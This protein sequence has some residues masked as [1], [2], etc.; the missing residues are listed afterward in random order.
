MT[1]DAFL[2]AFIELFEAQAEKA[3]SYLLSLT[4]VIGVT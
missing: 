1:T 2:V 3:A 4:F